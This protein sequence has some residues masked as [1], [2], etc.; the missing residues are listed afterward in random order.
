MKNKL[1]PLI[2]LFKNSGRLR[3]EDSEFKVSMGYI[4]SLRPA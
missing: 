4:V 2:I 3:K 1:S